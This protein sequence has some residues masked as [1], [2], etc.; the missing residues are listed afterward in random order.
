VTSS[1]ITDD[2][3]SIL[4]ISLG[5]SISYPI[6]DSDIR[7]WAIAVYYPDPAPRLFWDADYAKTT[8]YGGIVAPEEFNPFAWGARETFTVEPPKPALPPDP[9]LVAVGASEHRYGVQPPDLRHALNGG[10]EVEHTTV[11][12]R[13]GDVITSR[14]AIV[15]YSEREGRLGLMLFTTSESRWT[16]QRDELVR[17]D[18]MTLI[19][20]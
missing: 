7:K 3:R 6:T 9:A 4:G 20:Y 10:V 18:R 14:P 12:M 1:V 8:P 13:P 16:N 17:I 19:R 2:M 5:G 11:R 15:D